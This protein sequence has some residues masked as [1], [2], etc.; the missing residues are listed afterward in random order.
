MIIYIAQFNRLPIVKA[1]PY[2]LVNK[3]L[4]QPLDKEGVVNFTNFLLIPVTVFRLLYVVLLA[5]KLYTEQRN[6][7]GKNSKL[8]MH[9]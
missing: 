1:E 2:C 5:F 8:T 3:D 7:E 9:T 4:S 6:S